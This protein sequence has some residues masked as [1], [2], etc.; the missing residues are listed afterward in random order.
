[1][2]FN[3][4]EI[5]EFDLVLNKTDDMFDPQAAR[6]LDVEKHF[7][8]LFEEHEVPLLMRTYGRALKIAQVKHD[9]TALKTLFD[10]RDNLRIELDG[11][12]ESSSCDSQANF[13]S[14][15]GDEIPT[16]V[17]IFLW[18]S[19]I[20][21]ETP[22]ADVLRTMKIEEE[23]NEVQ[24]LVYAHGFYDVFHI[25][26]AAVHRY[27]TRWK[28]RMAKLLSFD[29]W[30]RSL[31]RH[32]PGWEKRMESFQK[33]NRKLLEE[34]NPSRDKDE[35][36]Y[37][38]WFCS[39]IPECIWIDIWMDE[40]KSN[41][42]T[43][44][45]FTVGRLNRTPPVPSKRSLIADFTSLS[46]S[47]NFAEM[48]ET[49]HQVC[50]FWVR[51][52]SSIV[53][54]LLES[55]KTISRDVA[56]TWAE[57]EAAWLASDDDDLSPYGQA[58]FLRVHQQLIPPDAMF[59]AWAEE[60]REKAVRGQVSPAEVLLWKL[61]YEATRVGGLSRKERALE[62]L[63]EIQVTEGEKGFVQNFCDALDVQ[64]HPILMGNFDNLLDDRNWYR[65]HPIREE[66]WPQE[67]AE[68]TFLW[69]N[70]LAKTQAAFLREHGHRIP[71]HVLPET[72]VH[73]VEGEGG[74]GPISKVLETMGIEY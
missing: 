33:T 25:Y 34:Y 61:Q 16:K 38:E 29:V 56:T 21:K 69:R 74:D 47:H 27:P 8:R 52:D 43:P 60:A 57:I 44:A 3:N 18:T 55:W 63:V 67:S 46:C 23:T 1:M 40:L 45:S 28:L 4:L 51:D 15:F 22:L 53:P 66:I 48:I 39:R 35:R 14:L 65:S 42:E 9:E 58:D 59:S 41:F 71:G 64:P 20:M 2:S 11:F 24:E 37:L 7:E 13:F 19:A 62:K 36:F 70:T 31:S 10:G 68:L 26:T 17:W 32:K 72:L 73:E 12:P 6:V 54:T 30:K 50:F 49:Y 5:I